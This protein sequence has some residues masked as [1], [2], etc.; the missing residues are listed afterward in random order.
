MLARTSLRN[1]LVCWDSV[2]QSANSAKFADSSSSLQIC[3]LSLQTDI[4]LHTRLGVR[5]ACLSCELCVEGTGLCSMHFH[6]VPGRAP[7][8]RMFIPHTVLGREPSTR[9][10]IPHKVLGRE[11]STGMFIPH[12]VQGSADICLCGA[13]QTKRSSCWCWA[14]RPSNACR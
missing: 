11:P 9:M 3:L 2:D 1:G 4:I 14:Q 5:R 10:F 6:K 8:T 12:K 7:S 13:R